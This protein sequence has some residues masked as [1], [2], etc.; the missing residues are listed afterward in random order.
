[1]KGGYKMT[2]KQLRAAFEDK[3][4]TPC[5]ITE[6]LVK[7]GYQQ[8]ERGSNC[9]P[10]G[11][12]DYARVRD[13]EIDYRRAMPTQW[14]HTIESYCDR[15]S[16]DHIV[17]NISCG[18]LI[19]WWAEML[20]C[21]DKKELNE[22]VDRIIESGKPINRKDKTKPQVKYSRRKWNAEIKKL[23]YSIVQEKVEKM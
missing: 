21:V 19:V 17:K 4:N 12:I 1:M 6:R 2:V 18:E 13:V 5:P 23:C 7:A 20:E 10:T 9:E 22:L 14:W 8:S 16:D 3:K 15:K 11:Y